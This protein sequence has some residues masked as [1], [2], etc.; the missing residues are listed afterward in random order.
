M[1]FLKLY[2]KQNILYNVI[3]HHNVHYCITLA[4]LHQNVSE[5]MNNIFVNVVFKTDKR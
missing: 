1:L 2:V 3:E 5:I 4:S